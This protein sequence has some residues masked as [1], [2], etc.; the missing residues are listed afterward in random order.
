MPYA[1]TEQ[2]IAMLSSILKSNIAVQVSI[3]IM[4]TFVEIRKYM[5]DTLYLFKQVNAIE[6]R[7]IES[8]LERKNF[9]D[10]TKKQ[11]E[12][13]FQYISDHEEDNQK[14][15]YDGQIFDAFNLMTQ[16]VQQAKNTIIL[17]DGYVDVVTLNI[18]AKKNIGV[19]VIIYTLPSAKLTKQDIAK[20]NAQYPSLIV[21]RTK[22]FH[23]R[24]L[25]IDGKVGYH[26]GASI[27]D[28][29]KKCFGIN[30]IGDIGVIN[31]LIQRAKLT[32]EKEF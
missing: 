17:I 5:S 12:Q 2:G 16:L 1:F 14:I 7:Q 23:D 31:D 30:Q 6:T 27:N 25:L 15:F 8:E 18:L 21:K 28:A 11:L 10:E 24:F 13:V 29:G 26:I 4:D 22:A 20:F 9:E 3:N 32:S 19:D